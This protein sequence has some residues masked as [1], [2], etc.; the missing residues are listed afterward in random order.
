MVPN[1]P[2]WAASSALQLLSAT[3]KP[4]GMQR[5]KHPI[6]L[7]VQM[8]IPGTWMA[9]SG[10]HPFAQTNLKLVQSKPV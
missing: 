8:Q 10:A 5:P 1:R 7:L 2:Q 9:T 3:A 6:D 4:Q